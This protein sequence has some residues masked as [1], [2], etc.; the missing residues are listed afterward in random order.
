VTGFG[1]AGHALEMAEGS[2]ATLVFELSR[3]PLLPGAEALAHRPFLT[4]ATVTN[5]DYVRPLLR[6]EGKPDPVRLEF[7]YDPQTSGGLLISVPAE[8]ADTLVAALQKRG[9][10]TACVVGEVVER[11][12]VALIL[13]A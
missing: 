1:L 7:F 13:R 12:D 10:R 5:A 2:R 9:A 11:Q 8:K 4:R 6:I 3:L